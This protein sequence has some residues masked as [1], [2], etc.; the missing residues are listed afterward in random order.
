MIKP[1]RLATLCLSAALWFNFSAADAAEQS[2][3]LPPQCAGKTGAALDQCMRDLTTPTT[4]EQLEPNGYKPN[5]AA[6]MNC[7]FVQSADQG[8]CIAHNEIVLECRKPKYQDFD[9][10]A[11][12]LITR[13]QTP[14]AADCSRVAANQ[15]ASCELRNKSRA[16][17]LQDPWDYFLCIGEKLY[18]K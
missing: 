9:A 13:P 3:L 12:N 14:V 10:C 6:L 7:N 16:E 18:G 17:C 1:L 15:R 2:T 5:P 11:R 8:F 4:I